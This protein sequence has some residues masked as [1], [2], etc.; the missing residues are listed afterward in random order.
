M[1]PADF[2]IIIIITIIIFSVCE[3]VGG[4]GGSRRRE[5]AFCGAA[6]IEKN[7]RKK[8]DVDATAWLDVG[9]T[10]VCVRN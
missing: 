7:L 2:F 8:V 9:L 1:R 4:G 3:C 10:M 6:R 5:G